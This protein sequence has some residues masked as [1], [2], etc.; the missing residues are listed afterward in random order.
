MK[1]I[2]R[3]FLEDKIVLSVILL[4]AIVIFLHA[5]DQHPSFAKILEILDYVITLFFIIEVVVN[6]FEYGWKDYIKSG[7]NK[8]DF[9][10]VVASSPSLLFAFDDLNELGVEAILILRLFRIFKFFRFLRFVPGIEHL[11]NGIQRAIK[12]SVLVILAFFVFIVVLSIIG[13]VLFKHI[14][15]ENFGNP[16]ISMYSMFKVFTVEGWY[17]VPDNIA[18]HVSPPTAFFVR[19]FFSFILIAGGIF[20]LSLVNSIFV[21]SMVSD[22][23]SDLE[24]KID[25]LNKKIEK[26][27]EIITKNNSET[28]NL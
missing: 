14:E 9:F 17:E 11:L 27:T 5:F 22:S 23:N 28:N 13:C 25:E 20:G 19:F 10:V 26:L 18:E 8:F 1:F 24:C 2:K 12:S 15:P 7:W 3:I 6:I 21:D 4:S 16:L